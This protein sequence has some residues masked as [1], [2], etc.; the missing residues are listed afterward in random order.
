[1][2]TYKTTIPATVTE[3][4]GIHT[5]VDPCTQKPIQHCGYRAL[6]QYVRKPPEERLIL[7]SSLEDVEPKETVFVNF[8]TGMHLYQH[9]RYTTVSD[10]AHCAGGFY[11]LN[12]TE[13]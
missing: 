5:V 2:I 13:A 7:C 12:G 8:H 10:A 11:F 9:N 1:M 3:P 4:I 6:L